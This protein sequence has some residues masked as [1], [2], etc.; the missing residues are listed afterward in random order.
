L[1]ATRN[2]LN[3]EKLTAT[4]S[5]IQNFQEATCSRLS[6]LMREVER[7][8]AIDKEKAQLDAD[9]RCHRMLASVLAKLG[10]PNYFEDHGL[11]ASHRIP[12][13]QSGNWLL[14]SNVFRRW[15]DAELAS[16]HAAI[17]LSGIPG[18]GKIEQMT[19]PSFRANLCIYPQ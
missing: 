17:Y 9:D 3:E 7:N 14:N 5:E 18:A 13:T 16:G 2:L 12:E 8:Y 6:S 4:M 1:K 11:A 15:S 19:R 10:D